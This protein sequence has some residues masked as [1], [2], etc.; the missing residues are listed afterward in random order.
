M[1][2]TLNAYHT[3]VQLNTI[4]KSSRTYKH[5]WIF[6]CYWTGSDTCIYLCCGKSAPAVIFLMTCKY[7]TA[8]GAWEKECEPYSLL[9]WPTC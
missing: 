3:A 6:N 4:L 7:I 1:T 8:Y 2:T 5:V 9:Y